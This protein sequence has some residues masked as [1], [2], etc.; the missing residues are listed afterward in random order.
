MCEGAWEP[1]KTEW[2][3][4][5]LFMH[6][7]MAALKSCMA[8]SQLTYDIAHGI[9]AAHQVC[10]VARRIQVV[11]VAG[12]FDEAAADFL[13]ALPNHCAGKREVWVDTLS[14][15]QAYVP[16]GGWQ[17]MPGAGEPPAQ[18]KQ[19]PCHHLASPLSARPSG[20]APSSTVLQLTLSEVAS[21]PSG[22]QNVAPGL[23]VVPGLPDVLARNPDVPGIQ[24]VLA[25][26]L[27]EPRPV[28]LGGM[29][30][31]A[32]LSVLLRHSGQGFVPRQT[33]HAVRRVAGNRGVCDRAY[34]WTGPDAEISNPNPY[35]PSPWIA[36]I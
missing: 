12:T 11:D 18:F 4:N 22:S 24:D 36:L 33:P 25:G 1:V 30:I 31:M 28:G 35:C 29:P 5:P 7:V 34:P 26:I 20:A 23:V 19:P 15:R 14:C 27:A 9:V 8:P 3:A 2:K 16:L 6:R 21:V 32:F 13:A 17:A 10:P